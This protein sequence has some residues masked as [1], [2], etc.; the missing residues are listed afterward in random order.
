[1]GRELGYSDRSASNLLVLLLVTNLEV[2]FGRS[3]RFSTLYEEQ[4]SA[5]FITNAE[6]GNSNWL[7]VVAANKIISRCSS[8]FILNLKKLVCANEEIESYK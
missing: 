7:A 2:Y 5:G 1:M 6:S 8:Q 3:N 4:L